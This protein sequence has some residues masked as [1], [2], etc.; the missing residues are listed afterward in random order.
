[1]EDLLEKLGVSSEDFR[2]MRPMDLIRRLD[3]LGI[4]S[5]S[6]ASMCFQL[7]AA[8]GKSDEIDDDDDL[9]LEDNVATGGAPAFDYSHVPAACDPGP[10]GGAWASYHKNERFYDELEAD[11]TG[12]ELP[13]HT[14]N[15]KL[16]TETLQQ[17]F[18]THKACPTN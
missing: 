3:E 10:K 18:P 9:E 14:A 4:D 15:E 16:V 12:E 6:A 8:A 7:H 17:R 1:M 5:S 11:V 2:R 13:P